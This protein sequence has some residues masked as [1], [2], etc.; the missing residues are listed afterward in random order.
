MISSYI[1]VSSIDVSGIKSP[2][3]ITIPSTLDAISFKLFIPFFVSILAQILG[4]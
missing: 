2:L 1:G 4:V 3:P